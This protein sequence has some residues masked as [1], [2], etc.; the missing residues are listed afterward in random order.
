M[1]I[2]IS[3][4]KKILYLQLLTT[5]LQWVSGMRFD[6]GFQWLG[7]CR[8]PPILWETSL[9]QYLGGIQQ[10]MIDESISSYWGLSSS[11]IIKRERWSVSNWSFIHSFHS[12][13]HPFIHSYTCS[14][15]EPY[16]TSLRLFSVLMDEA[17]NHFEDLLGISKVACMIFCKQL[18]FLKS[19]EGLSNFLVSSSEIHTE[20]GNHFVRERTKRIDR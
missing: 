17:L 5:M 1:Q 11:T 10:K 13:I 12:F 2:I 19:G 8:M 16:D 15:N 9:Q 4:D 14:M 18:F 7:V 6:W 20:E 3:M